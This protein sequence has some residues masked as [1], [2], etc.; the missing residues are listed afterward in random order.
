MQETPNIGLIKPSQEDHYNIDDFNT[1]ADI[2]DNEITS[3]TTAAN[4]HSGSE[5]TITV[6]AAN[7]GGTGQTSL[8][9]TR[10]AMGLGNTTGVLPAANGGTGHTSLQAARN[11]MGLGNTTAQLP[12]A[13]GGTGLTAQPSMLTNLGT[14]AAANVLQASPRPGVTGTLPI[15]NGGTGA[16]TRVNAVTN[17]FS[18]VQTNAGWF[19][20]LG[21]GGWSAS[22][23]ITAAN[24]RTSM[25]AAPIPTTAAANGQ[26]AKIMSNWNDPNIPGGMWGGTWF[27]YIVSNRGFSGN[28]N[29]THINVNVAGG[30]AI[31]ALNEWMRQE[32][33]IANSIGVNVW[34]GGFAWRVQ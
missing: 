11:A 31:H 15:A 28:S 7:R 2:I 33:L 4:P 29:P 19:M 3:H 34:F 27:W 18:P 10:N 21:S 24:A 23:H 26:I 17:L 1:N 14:T 25:G 30:N 22:G 20:A 12:V 13:N 9:A 16:M 32:I 6:L 8:Q 5:P